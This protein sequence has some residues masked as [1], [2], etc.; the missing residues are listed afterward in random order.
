LI[1]ERK[2]YFGA[3]GLDEGG[4]SGAALGHGLA[5]VPARTASDSQ[6]PSQEEIDRVIG[7]ITR[8][9]AAVDESC[10]I[11]TIA[12]PKGPGADRYRMLRMRLKVLR[13]ATNLHV[14]LVTS[15]L[16]KDGKSVVAMNLAAM[17][18]KDSKSRTLLIDGDLHRPSLEGYLGLTED[19]GL[20]ECLDDPDVDVLGC[21]RQVEPLGFYF[22]PAG[23][24]T[25]GA[26][27]E[28]LH[29]RSVSSV[30]RRLRPY[31]DWIVLDS[32]PVAA[33]SDAILFSRI[34]DAT[35][36]VARA[37]CTSR[38]AIA[39][40]LSA[41]GTERIGAIVLNAEEGLNALYSKY[42]GYYGRK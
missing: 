17:L 2:S 40:A 8:V 5:D 38:D 16:P 1:K 22:L 27:S 6:D 11:A 20:A 3:S 30:I 35:V 14:L 13:Q 25:G 10:R 32:P 4:A 33:L 23:Q 37:H 19:V 28:L 15:A 9:T 36:F 39:D 31:F 26:P 18:A 41:I 29:E 42:S 24:A 21:I 34:V 12:D 7:K